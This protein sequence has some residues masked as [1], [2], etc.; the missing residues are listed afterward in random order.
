MFLGNGGL[1]REIA[2]SLERE[3]E[4]VEIKGIDLSDRAVG[5]RG[6]RADRLFRSTLLLNLQINRQCYLVAKA[7]PQALP[8]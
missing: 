5:Y 6:L 8:N 4:N 2:L 7:C 3:I 1:R